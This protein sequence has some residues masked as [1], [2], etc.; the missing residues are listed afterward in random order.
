M[1]RDAARLLRASI[2]PWTAEFG[3]I[4][5]PASRGNGLMVKTS[6]VVERQLKT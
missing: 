5:I 4:I 1:Q 2:V 3:L 6:F